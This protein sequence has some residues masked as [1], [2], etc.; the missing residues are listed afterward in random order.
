[1]KAMA[2]A[3]LA[4]ATLAFAAPALILPALILPARAEYRGTADAQQAC[5]PDVFRL[6]GRFIPDSGAIAACLAGQKS[7]LSPACH[8]VFSGGPRRRGPSVA[9]G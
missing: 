7:N 5:T 4:S 6:C 9:R 1:M 3:A 2:R 8:K